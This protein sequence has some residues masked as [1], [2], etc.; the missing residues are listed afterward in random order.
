MSDHH[1]VQ[2]GPE[3]CRKPHFS[4]RR[5]IRALEIVVKDYAEIQAF[6]RATHGKDT[7]QTEVSMDA[8]GRVTGVDVPAFISVVRAW[9]ETFG[10]LAGEQT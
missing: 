8:T 2:R 4:I 6:L 10:R 1:F 3:S 5:R 9:L 7:V